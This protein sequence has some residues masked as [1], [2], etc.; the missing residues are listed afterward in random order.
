MKDNILEKKRWRRVI[1]IQGILLLAMLIYCFKTPVKYEFDVNNLLISDAT[2]S[3]DAVGNSI[4]ISGEIAGGENSS[5]ARWIAGSDK[6]NLPFGIYEIEAFYTSELY[7]KENGGGSCEDYTAIIQMITEGNSMGVSYNPLRL[8]D[9]YTN[10]KERFFIQS[11]SGVQDLQV[12]ICFMGLGELTVEKIVLRELPLWRLSA[13]IG[14][15]LFFI[16]IDGLYYYF[17]ETIDKNKTEIII[18]LGTIVFSSIPLFTDFLF[19]GAGHDLEFHLDRILSLAK[20]LEDGN[21]ISPISTEAIN[22]YGYA[23]PIFYG[24]LFLYIPAILYNLAL[25]L[26]TC[27][28]IYVFL[29]NGAT[30]IISYICFKE[31][32][33]DNRIAVIGS[34]IY[35]VAPYRIC[36]IYL[37]GAVGEYTAMTFMPLV[38]YG[39]IM[40]YTKSDDDISWKDWL[41]ITFGLSGMIQSHMLS[42]E[43]VAVFI[44]MVCIVCIRKT[45]ELKRFIALSK[46]ALLTVV[47]NIGFLVSLLDSMQMQINVNSRTPDFI[48]ESGVYWTQLFSPFMTFGGGSF[49]NGMSGEMP[50]TLGFSLIFGLVLFFG[51]CSKRREW[52]IPAEKIMT[53]AICGGM[54]IVALL[55]A[56]IYFPWNSIER[57]SDAFARFFGMTQFAWRYI[58]IA[59]VLAT[60]VGVIG[61][62]ILKQKQGSLIAEIYGIVMIG[63]TVMCVGLF[64]TQFCNS[65][66]TKS[67]YANIENSIMAVLGGG[68]EY[69][70]TETDVDELYKREITPNDSKIC[71]EQYAYSE[72]I[73]TFYCRN[74]SNEIIHVEIPLLNY[75]NY[76]AC[77][78]NNGIELEIIN[79]MNNR[80]GVVIPAQYEGM[81]KV[82]YRIPW[83]W[84][85]SYII[86]CLT[87]SGIVIG[88]SYGRNIK[89]KG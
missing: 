71:I 60:F 65:T 49:S 28:Q 23:T 2:A 3:I 50:L 45:V 44:V 25:P 37:R 22:G 6:I 41:P 7:T 16:F 5:Y 8:K 53:G 42:C 33:K 81:V 47:M 29:V 61:L 13:L 11:I 24:Q 67:Y 14:L 86:S 59:T 27:Y 9:G 76:Y 43:M 36:N 70:P 79:G 68:G 54:T 30:A 75:D 64:F 56:T 84:T 21:W 46:A 72:G 31:L 1:A 48:Q 52:D 19:V 77:D 4:C 74:N 34:F 69:L 18:L 80:V 32:I 66:E 35:T 12:K 78:V 17:F 83:Y 51:C 38:V 10:N 87:L 63:A 88:V 40:V 85:L 82:E 62:N 89:K 55:F 39:F 26:H 58:A 15:L 20:M 57:V 73:T